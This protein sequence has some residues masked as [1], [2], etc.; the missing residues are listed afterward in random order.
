MYYRR[1]LSPIKERFDDWIWA[2]YFRINPK[3]LTLLVHIDRVTCGQVA[4]SIFVH[5][6]SFSQETY[7]FQLHRLPRC[8][9]E[10]GNG[11]DYDRLDDVRQL[12]TQLEE[13]VAR[14]RQPLVLE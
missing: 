14:R 10:I 4:C 8:F 3:R 5:R 12:L 11:F 7:S 13:Y 2:L 1:I 6:G 9:D